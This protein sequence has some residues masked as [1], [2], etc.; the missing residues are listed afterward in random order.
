MKSFAPLCY[1]LY[2]VLLLFVIFVSCLFLLVLF[3][4]GSFFPLYGNTTGHSILHTFIWCCSK[5]LYCISNLRSNFRVLVVRKRW[6]S[7]SGDCGSTHSGLPLGHICL[8]LVLEVEILNSLL[9]CQ[10]LLSK[11]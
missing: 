6:V 8:E 9:N 11:R 2:M 7:N 10:F 1:Y 5:T 3:V 4:N